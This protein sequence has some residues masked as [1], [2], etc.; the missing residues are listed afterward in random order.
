MKAVVV[1][2]S[3]YGTTKQ[4]AEWIAEDLHADIFEADMFHADD[5]EKYDTVIFGGGVYVGSILGIAMVMN[6]MGIL[7]HKNTFV[8]TVGLDSP[9]NDCHMENLLEK[10]FTDEMKKK[11]HVY[12]FSGAI[13]Y[14]KLTFV[15]KM[16]MKMVNASMREKLDLHQNH[17][18]RE[19]VAPLVLAAEV[20]GRE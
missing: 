1:Y 12:H 14:E 8:F 18:S 17:V 7:R 6:N 9:E 10:N 3:K 19:A 2:K 4:Y 16:M 20:F 15:H 13:E 11:I 5:F